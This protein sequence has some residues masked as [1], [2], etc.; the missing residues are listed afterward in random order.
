LEPIHQITF[1]DAWGRMPRFLMRRMSF[2]SPPAPAVEG[3]LGLGLRPGAWEEV[4]P[5]LSKPPSLHGS[6]SE[7]QGTGLPP[8]EGIE[9]LFV[10]RF[11]VT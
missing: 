11:R 3:Y 4:D 10:V 1:G 6:L 8:L 9:R 5:L 2:R 7:P